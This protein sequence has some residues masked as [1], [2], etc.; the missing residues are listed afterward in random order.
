[1]EMLKYISLNY[2][3]PEQYVKQHESIN[4]CEALIRPN[5]TISNVHTSHQNCLVKEW[6][7]KNKV[8][9]VN[10]YDMLPVNDFEEKI[11][12]DTGIIQIW[13]D[14]CKVPKVI[15]P[16]QNKTL[17]ILKKNAPRVI[18]SNFKIVNC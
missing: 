16:Q 17:E 3:T 14:F 1:M 7:D 15:T 11:I 10:A 5:G 6:C 8:E 4:Y 13:Y 2:L 12:N 18:A 9:Y